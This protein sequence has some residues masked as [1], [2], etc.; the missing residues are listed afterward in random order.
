MLT[1]L[2]F[3]P[4]CMPINHFDKKCWIM[5]SKPLL[6][7]V[8]YLR[9]FWSGSWS[10]IHF[11]DKWRQVNQIRFVRI[12][13]AFMDLIE[14]RSYKMNVRRPTLLIYQKILQFQKIL[15]PFSNSVWPKLNAAACFCTYTRHFR[16]VKRVYKC[17]SQ[18]S[19]D[20]TS[21]FICWLY[22]FILF[23]LLRHFLRQKKRPS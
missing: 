15:F 20:W 13:Q 18:D 5:I 23:L 21:M 6:V 4:I 10:N 19:N 22:A 17:A 2:Q 11:K 7:W 8:Y 16:V 1:N 9:S 12:C 3:Q 14:T